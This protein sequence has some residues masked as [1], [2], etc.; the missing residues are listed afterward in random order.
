[1][2]PTAGYIHAN[3]DRCGESF[4][5]E[6]LVDGLCEACEFLAAGEEDE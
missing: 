4:D 1:M 5:I 3:C 2:D 6:E